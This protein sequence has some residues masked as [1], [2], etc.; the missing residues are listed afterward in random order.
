MTSVPSP[1]LYE[2]PGRLRGGKGLTLEVERNTGAPYSD[3][4]RQHSLISVPNR[5]AININENL[6]PGN[7]RCY[8]IVDGDVRAKTNQERRGSRRQ[9]EKEL[10]KKGKVISL[11]SSETKTHKKVYSQLIKRSRA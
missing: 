5:N 2:I 1:C 11:P 10:R 3:C 4:Q 7:C 6:I 8:V 9:T